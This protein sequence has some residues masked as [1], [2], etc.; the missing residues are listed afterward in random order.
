[1]TDSLLDDLAADLKP[2]LPLRSAPLWLGA[3][4][5]LF[6]AA[7]Y[8][9]KFYGMR[10]ELVGL[11]H[12]LWPVKGMVVLKPLIFLVTGASA[13]WAVSGLAR[14]EGRLKLLHIAPI[15]VLLTLVVI[16]LIVDLAGSGM[17]DI[18]KD[19]DG[20]VLV[21]FT[22]ILCGGMAGLAVMW[23]LWL[24]RSATSYPVTLGAMAGLAT[25][26][27]MEA[28]YA[29]HCNMDAPV[30]ILL[31]YGLAVALFSG[32]AALLGGRLLRW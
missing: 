6:L 32:F 24:R 25:A 3:T 17:G 7:I 2:V 19:L 1:M 5:G 29:L 16:S 20:G 31:V 8:I 21:C 14:P 28:A 30:Y 9:L 4:A 23:R 22:T 18:H 10:P 11:M 27:L 26:S 12:G 13:L 15:A